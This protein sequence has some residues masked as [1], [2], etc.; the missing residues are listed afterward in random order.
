MSTGNIGGFTKK[1]TINAMIFDRY[2]VG[3]DAGPPLF[4]LREAP[5]CP[6]G[7]FSIL[8]RHEIA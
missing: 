5:L 2:C 7:F 6:S 8:F 1:T 4:S 3:N